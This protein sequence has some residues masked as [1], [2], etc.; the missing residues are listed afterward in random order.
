M[1]SQKRRRDE[2][3]HSNHTDSDPQN[4]P[5]FKKRKNIHSKKERISIQNSSISPDNARLEASDPATNIEPCS[6][7]SYTWKCTI[8]TFDNTIIKQATPQ[9]CTMC[10]QLQEN[11][12]QHSDIDAAFNPQQD[13]VDN[14]K[15]NTE[16]TE[17][18]YAIINNKSNH[19]QSNTH[20]K[21]NKP[22]KMKQL[23]QNV[24]DNVDEGRSRPSD[25]A[26]NEYSSG[27]SL[28]DTGFNAKCNTITPNVE[29]HPQ[30]NAN[31]YN[32]RGHLYNHQNNHM[33]FDHYN[34][35]R[36]HRRQYHRP[37]RRHRPHKRHRRRPEY[38]ESHDGQ[39]GDHMHYP[40][41]E[42][43]CQNR[44][45]QRTRTMEKHT[46]NAWQSSFDLEFK[47]LILNA[48]IYAQLI[49]RPIT[50]KSQWKGRRYKATK[51]REILS[52]DLQ[53]QALDVNARKFLIQLISS[54]NIT[55]I[56]EVTPEII[57]F[58][59]IT[60]NANKT[61]DEVI[62]RLRAIQKAI[63]G[64]EHPMDLR[65]KMIYETDELIK[66]LREMFKII[67]EKSSINSFS[68]P[69]VCKDKLLF[70]AKCVQG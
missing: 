41:H 1:A 25:A 26:T 51:L 60:I 7:E 4:E 19:N 17:G 68:E 5:A 10:E 55:N 45:G 38:D 2:I 21:R 3:Y 37:H 65:R 61:W 43:V 28:W 42:F 53:Q 23:A 32:G 64:S 62:P 47:F 67:D 24:L 44:Q 15:T 12:Q 70:G 14:S 49:Q 31:E 50:N 54:D 40:R 66:Q 6:P 33:G 13:N 20:K 8:C 46:N 34:N 18:S 35:N 16:L 58:A 59:Q 52:L 69:N 27:K 30:Y 29:T 39:R 48:G 9:Q 63:R 36:G 57:K 56:K 22:C 11:G